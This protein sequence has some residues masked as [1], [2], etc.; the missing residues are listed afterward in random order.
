MSATLAAPAHGKPPDVSLLN[1]Y[2][3][4]AEHS[5]AM[6]ESAQRGD[7][8]DVTR[9]EKAC[10]QLIDVLRNFSSLKPA[11]EDERQECMRLVRKVLADDA[12]IREIAQPWLRELDQILRPLN[13]RRPVHSFR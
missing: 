11:H 12:A 4:F 5:G 7:W 13:G 3:I 1:I 2:A 6:L 8:D 9:R 10:S